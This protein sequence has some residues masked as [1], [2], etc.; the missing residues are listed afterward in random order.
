MLLDFDV[1]TI[2]A[3]QYVQLSAVT[4]NYFHRCDNYL[5]IATYIIYCQTLSAHASRVTLS[6]YLRDYRSDA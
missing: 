6:Q 4:C 5:Q 2:I 3:L 1:R